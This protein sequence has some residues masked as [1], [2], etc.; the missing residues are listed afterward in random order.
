VG[1]SRVFDTIFLVRIEIS[2]TE[3]GCGKTENKKKIR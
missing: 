3:L 1:F 2:I